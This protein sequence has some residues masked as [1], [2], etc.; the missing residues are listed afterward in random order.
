MLEQSF[1]EKLKEREAA[2][3]QQW[4]TASKAG[5]SATAPTIK[6][7]ASFDEASVKQEMMR[8][9]E[10]LKQDSPDDVP[11][12]IRGM[13]EDD[14]RGLFERIKEAFVRHE[15][16]TEGIRIQ[17]TSPKW[18][19]VSLFMPYKGLTMKKV[20]STVKKVLIEDIGVD[21]NRLDC[22]GKNTAQQ[23]Y[24]WYFM[25]PG[26]AK[27]VYDTIANAGD[28]EDQKSGDRELGW[29]IP[30]PNKT[31]D[32]DEIPL[33]ILNE[34]LYRKIESGEKTI[35]YRNLVTY[36]C[37][38]FF[39]TGKRVKAVRFQLGYSG[40]DGGEPE[41]MTWEVKDIMLVSE[42]GKLAPAMTNGKMSSFKNL[43]RVFPP[44]AY[45]IKLGNRLPDDIS[46]CDIPDQCSGDASST[47]IIESE[48]QQLIAGIKAGRLKSKSSDGYLVLKA[49]FYDAIE[50]GKKKVEYRDFTEYNLKR[51]IGIK[52][53]RFNRGYVK[54]APQMKW[55]VKKIVLLD[56][57]DSACDPFNVPDDFWPTTIALHLGKRIG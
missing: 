28:I 54:N 12:G 21:K 8:E 22:F 35:E 48:T 14:Y 51:T 37:D 31:K 15:I 27:D 38:K 2:I 44:V 6:S 24:E 13:T 29:G 10:L 9:L 43:P 4:A 11:T 32:T 47:T 55:E 23:M 46:M 34:D 57:D 40:K 26:L 50:S 56:D 18:W 20:G 25:P 30:I 42:H 39:G 16:P 52:T 53:V 17:L 5:K 41:R 1:E 7:T 45:A 36:Y 3:R 49:E 33:L 19:A